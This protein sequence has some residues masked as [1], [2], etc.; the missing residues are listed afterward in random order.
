MMIPIL[1]AE[2]FCVA[3]T[4]IHVA[5]TLVAMV[6]CKS[7]AAPM[8]APADAPAVSLVRPVCGIENHIEATLASAFRLDYP[9]YEIVFCVALAHDPVVPTVRR[10]MAAHPEV[11]A[12]LLIGNEKISDNPK[13][14][15]IYKGWRDTARDWIV[16]ADSNV[17]MPPD[18][19]QRLLAAW[20]PDTGLVCSPPVGCRPDGFWAELECAFLNTYQ[21]RFQYTADT[22]GLGFAQG[23][24]MLWRRA[25]LEPEGG[26]RAL[27]SELAEDAAATKVVRRAGLRVRLVDAPFEQP[28]GRRSAAEVWRRQV[29]W[30]RLRRTSFKACFMPEILAGG[31][32]PLLAAI[33]AVAHSDLPL[34]G[35]PT[36]A[37][38][39]YGCEAALAWAAGWHLTARSPLAWALRDLLLPA[40]WLNG[41]LGSAFVWRGNRMRAIESRGTV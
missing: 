16:L 33:F 27:A 22:L 15:N 3:T 36:L 7:P 21:A 4:A 23:K 20:R 37:A 12:R 32:W 17:F 40:I 11:P 25:L 18:Y 38:V 14:N 2:A 19:I 34:A 31:L 1:A 30:A 24:S 9:R 10:L 5:S 13:L 29:R 28:L 35:V 39:W 41:W 6:R 8:R 26:I